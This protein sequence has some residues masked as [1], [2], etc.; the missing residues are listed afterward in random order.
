MRASGKRQA[1]TLN[2]YFVDNCGDA[3]RFALCYIPGMPIR[4]ETRWLYPID[5]PLISKHIRFEVAGPHG[6]GRCWKCG[7]P[8]GHELRVL[9]DGRWFDV[10]LGVGA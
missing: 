3:Q 4:R 10:E 8:H 5:W 6:A 1:P 9:P 2:N 7:R